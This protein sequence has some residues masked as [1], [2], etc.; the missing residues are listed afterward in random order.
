MHVRDPRSHTQSTNAPKR[1]T[2]RYKNAHERSTCT[3]NPQMHMRDPHAH[4]QS[5]NAC[6]RSTYAHTIQKCT[7]EIHTQ[8]DPQMHAR[9][10][11]TGQSTNAC[12]RSTCTHTQ[13]KRRHYCFFAHRMILKDCCTPYFM[14]NKLRVV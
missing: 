14:H 7:P 4:K 13:S 10:S 1:S 6:D 3:Y 8:G 9:D 11:H 5:R 2:G 12:E